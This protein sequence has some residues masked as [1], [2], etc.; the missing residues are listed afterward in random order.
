MVAVKFFVSFI[1]NFFSGDSIGGSDPHYQVFLELKGV[2]NLSEEQRYKVRMISKKYW[3]HTSSSS[4]SKTAHSLPPPPPP[5]FTSWTC[6]CSE[7]RPS[8][9]L[10]ASKAA[11]DQWGCSWLRR[12]RLASFA[13]AWWNFQTR[14]PT[15]LKCTE[16]CAEKSM[17]TSSWD[18]PFPE[19]LRNWR[20]SWAGHR[21]IGACTLL[22][23]VSSVQL[24]TRSSVCNGV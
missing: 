24:F 14:H 7:T 13:S 19:R 3:A 9:G 20:I 17:R 1:F 2:R 8:T 6:V 16:C 21:N 10:F 22:C 12:E 5:F 15:P 11:S 18:V 4:F 23:W